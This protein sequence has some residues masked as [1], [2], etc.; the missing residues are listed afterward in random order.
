MDRSVESQEI[1][2]EDLAH[3]VSGTSGSSAAGRLRQPQHDQAAEGVPDTGHLVYP[4]G[5][6]ELRMEEEEDE[7]TH[8]GPSPYYT[9]KQTM[10]EAVPVGKRPV[11]ETHMT[12]AGAGAAGLVEKSK[13]VFS[14]GLVVG[15]QEK[16]GTTTGGEEER[17]GA[18]A[19]E[20]EEE[21]GGKEGR[22]KGGVGLSLGEEEEGGENEGKAVMEETAIFKDVEDVGPAPL[23]APPL[24]SPSGKL[25]MPAVE[26]PV[27]FK[28]SDRFPPLLNF[29]ISILL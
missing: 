6:K 4:P 28:I 1:I 27:R 17:G 8:A 12:G 14:G 18:F 7:H 13:P 26:I 11:E 21:Q 20:K 9:M 25:V 29:F 22:E 15:E 24:E 10:E 16:R 3:L 5:R 23:V 19:E 2:V